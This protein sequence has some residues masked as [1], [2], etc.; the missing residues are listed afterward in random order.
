SSDRAWLYAGNDLE[1]PTAGLETK[2]RALA[3]AITGRLPSYFKDKPNPYVEGDATAEGADAT[4]RTVKESVPDARLAVV[5]SSEIVSDLLLQL[6]QSPGG[7]VHR[8][9]LQLLQN[10]VDWSTED[11]DL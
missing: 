3:V 9:N 11:T 2:E 6:A 4:G 10:L 5:G 7:E 8:G 1:A